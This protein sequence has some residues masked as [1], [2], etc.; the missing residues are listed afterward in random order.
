MTR[1]KQCR[2]ALAIAFL[3]FATSCSTGP[4]AI[5]ATRFKPKKIL[6]K[7]LELYDTD[8]DELLSARELESSPGLK[9]ASRR[10]DTND[11]GSLDKEEVIGMVDL[12]NQKAIG[13]LSLR[14]NVTYKRRPLQGATI[15]LEPEPFLDELIEVAHGVTDE[16]GDAFITVPK[17]KRPIPDAPPGVQI[18]L[19]RVVI[20]KTKAG[21]ET[22]PAKYNQATELG[23]EVSFDDPG[24]QNGIKYDLR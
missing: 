5:P 20:S 1:V 12:W 9:S 23:Q 4:R 10:A 21:K 11:D 22:L 2:S 7:V 15:R 14:C 18:G 6:S 19:Y 24:V 13:L 17:E 8:G 16:F 3:L